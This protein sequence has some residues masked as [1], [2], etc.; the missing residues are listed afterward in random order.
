MSF[1]KSFKWEKK[2]KKSAKKH[3]GDSYK[4]Q[5]PGVWYKFFPQLSNSSWY[6]FAFTSIKG[7]YNVK[8]QYCSYVRDELNKK[9]GSK[10]KKKYTVFC[11]SVHSLSVVFNEVPRAI[12]EVILSYY[13]MSTKQ[14]RVVLRLQ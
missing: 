12:T 2:K 4:L 13:I 14:N 3:Q 7:K 11:I 9:T 5:G 10:D 1:L 8:T 6:V